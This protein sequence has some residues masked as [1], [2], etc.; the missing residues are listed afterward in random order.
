MS[1]PCPFLYQALSHAEQNLKITIEKLGAPVA[2][3]SETRNLVEET[4]H[5]LKSILVV[6]NF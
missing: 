6:F 5:P 3:L 4:E 1:L 2:F